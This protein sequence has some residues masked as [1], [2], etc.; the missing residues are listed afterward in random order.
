M[1]RVQRVIFVLR[2]VRFFFF[3][4]NESVRSSPVSSPLKSGAEQSHWKHIEKKKKKARKRSNQGF[5]MP[6]VAKAHDKKKDGCKTCP[7]FLYL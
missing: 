3:F 7:S 6:R 1:L 5:N 2:L 4:T